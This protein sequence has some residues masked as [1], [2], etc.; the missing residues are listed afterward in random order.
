[1]LPLLYQGSQGK[2]NRLQSEKSCIST[3]TGC[4]LISLAGHMTGLRCR[5]CTR[6]PTEH[7]QEVSGSVCSALE[8]IITH[9][10]V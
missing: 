8:F 1:M 5:P 4:S 10:Q 2:I 9:L 3:L 7:D 6:Y